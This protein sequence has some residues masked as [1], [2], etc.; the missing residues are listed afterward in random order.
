MALTGK[1]VVITGSTRGIGRAIASACAERGARLV[2]SSRDPDSVD[3]AVGELDSGGTD[4]VGLPA[5][6]SR[7][8]DLQALFDL[9]LER[10]GRV[11]AWVNNAGLSCGYRPLDEI[12]P[13]ELDRIA[14]VNVAGVMLG[15]RTVLPYFRENGG[16]LVNVAGR[17]YKGEATPFTAAYAATKAAVMSLTK[18]IA[19]ENKDV[20]VSIHAFVPGMVATDFFRDQK[21]SPRLQAS[22][23]NV[24]LALEALG[25]PVEEAG[26]GCAEILGQ[27]PGRETGKT[28]SMLRGG[29]LVRG[30]AKLMWWRMTGRMKPES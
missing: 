15:C 17:G 28:Y 22:R 26:A 1:V 23:G 19:A 8:E 2:V 16:V 7:A 18:S 12:G 5:D 11:D 4:V 3:R 27:E 9:A 25:V 21:V 14:R 24:D 30:I 29:R 20:P 6:V 13:E 10:F